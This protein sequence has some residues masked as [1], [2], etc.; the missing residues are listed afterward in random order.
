MVREASPS[1][2]VVAPDLMPFLP[3]AVMLRVPV[4]QIVT[5]EPS[6]HLITAFSALSL[7]AYSSSLFF[8]LSLSEFTEPSA[9]SIVTSVDLLQETGAVS[10]LSSSSPSRMSVTPVVPFFTSTLPSEQLPE[11]R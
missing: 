2:S 5:C 8:S 1:S 9:T 7:S 11:R 4:P 10:E 6:L 3:F